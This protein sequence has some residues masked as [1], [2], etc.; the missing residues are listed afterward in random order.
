[1]KKL[2]T[3]MLLAGLVAAGCEKDD[4]NTAFGDTVLYMP[5]ATVGASYTVPSGLDAASANYKLDAASGKVKV[6]LGVY[7]SGKEQGDAIS[8]QVGTDADTVQKMIASG[9]LDP[10]KHLAMPTA[11]YTLPSSVDLPSGA[12]SAAFY[13][14]L[15]VAALKNYPGKILA[16]AVNISAGDNRVSPALRQVLVLV[17]VNKLPL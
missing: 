15:D 10:A 3:I 13:L 1:M 11:V 16:L 9:A 2:C 4:K 17:D 8:V 5:Q 12:G 6:I 14:E 7:R